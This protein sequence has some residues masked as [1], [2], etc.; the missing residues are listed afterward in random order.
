[1]MYSSDGGIYNANFQTAANANWILS[2]HEH[3]L[4][5]CFRSHII[6]PMDFIA[7]VLFQVGIPVK[8]Q[9]Y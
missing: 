9:A 5:C 4:T 2:A 8:F 3:Y 1:M 7:T 6:Q